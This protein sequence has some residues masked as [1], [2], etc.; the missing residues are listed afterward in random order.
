MA[1]KKKVAKS[2]EKIKEEAD[3]IEEAM[4]ESDERGGVV[5]GDPVAECY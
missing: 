4:D 3:K 5:H 1:N 2:V